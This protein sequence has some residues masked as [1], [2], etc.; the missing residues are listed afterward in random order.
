M[1]GQPIAKLEIAAFPE[2]WVGRGNWFGADRRQRNATPSFFIMLNDIDESILLIFFNRVAFR[3]V[4][5][6]SSKIIS[7]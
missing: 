5:Q 4:W 3:A 2:I 1:R 7:D 6:T